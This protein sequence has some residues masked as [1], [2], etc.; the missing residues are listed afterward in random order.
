M[1]EPLLRLTLLAR[2]LIPFL[3]MMASC[4]LALHILFARLI[5]RRE[6]QVLGFFA[7]VT[8]PLTWPVRA[9]LPPGTAEARVRAI[10][11]AVYL[12]LW[13]VTDRLLRITPAG[14]G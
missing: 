5:A 6:S 13:V 14:A 3:F 11:L 2:V 8:A 4:Y 10:S 7:T 12:L 1:D 9:V